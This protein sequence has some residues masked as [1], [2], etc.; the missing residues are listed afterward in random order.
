[1]SGIRAR[2]DLV[3]VERGH[4]DSRARAQEAIAAGLVSVDGRVL[5]KASEPI[6]DGAAITAEQPHPWVSRGGVKLAAALAAFGVA[7]KG[8][9]CLDV[10]SSTGGFSHVLLTGGAAGIIAIDTGRDQFHASLRH[11][12]RIT[13]MEGTDIRRLTPADMPAL[14]DLAVIDVSFISL[15]LV[16]PAVTAL[17]APAAELVALVKPQFEVGRAHVGKNGIV[18]DEAAR[19]AAILRVRGV[20]ERLGWRITGQI[21]SPIA[22]GDGNREVL[23]HGVRP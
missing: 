23:I 14:P 6:A 10:G 12:P 3:L 19:E 17:L 18:T 9:T 22:G 21:D 4:F 8:R 16:L 13:L 7:P 20:A 5:R 15:A 11:D 2:A 1:M